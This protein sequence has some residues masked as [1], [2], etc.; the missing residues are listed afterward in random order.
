M[1]AASASAATEAMIDDIRPY[2][3]RETG[4]RPLWIGLA[5]I[6]VAGLF[7]FTALEARRDDRVAPAVRARASDLSAVS[8]LAV[9]PLYVPPETSAA[10]TIRPVPPVT[11]VTPEPQPLSPVMLR[12]L[13]SNSPVQPQPLP[14]TAPT[15][16]TVPLNTGPAIVYDGSTAPGSGTGA[17]STADTAAIAIRARPEPAHDR[18][19]IVPQGTLIA[20]VLETALDTTQPGQTRALV[21]NDVA[22]LARGRTLIPRGSRLFGDYKADIGQGQNRIQIIWT[23]LVRPDGVT[24]ALDSPAVDRLGRAGVRGKVDTHFFERLAGALLQSSLDVG[25]AFAARSIQSGSVVV[26]LPG[27]VSSATSQLVPPAPKP[28]IRVR[29]GARIGVL[30]ARDLDF[31]GVGDVP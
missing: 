2:V 9:P 4:N 11:P 29:P 19:R 13:P 30:V 5:T 17:T 3:G 31:S 23:H 24:V 20:A 15:P 6:G 26:A 1:K 27:S 21:S 16:P 22:N 7:L 12:P 14:M 28:T 8:P 25:A 10:P 18:T